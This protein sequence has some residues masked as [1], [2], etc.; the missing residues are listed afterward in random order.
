VKAQNTEFW[1][2]LADAYRDDLSNWKTYLELK[3]E[4]SFKIAQVIGEQW[5]ANIEQ[6]ESQLQAMQDEMMAMMPSAA[7]V[8]IGRDIGKMLE[9]VKVTKRIG[10]EL[11]K[12]MA[13]IDFSKFGFSEEDNKRQKDQADLALVTTDRYLELN[14][15]L[16]KIN[17]QLE[18]NRELQ[19][20]AE[21]KELI[22]LF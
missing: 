8:G 14:A 22:N 15:A 13:K 11:D 18:E 7:D 20:L 9:Y 16:E 6:T 3:E 17:R 10:D 1:N 12:T 5:N 21:G 19:N 2:G 4:M